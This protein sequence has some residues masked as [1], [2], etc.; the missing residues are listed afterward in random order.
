VLLCGDIQREA[1][2]TLV[3]SEAVVSADVLELPHHGSHHRT[4]E[5][6]V[7]QVGPQVTLQSTGRTRW[8]RTRARWDPAL[9][10]AEHLVTARDG[11]CWVRIDRQG[12]IRCGRY[13]VR[14]SRP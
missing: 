1:M 12:S 2:E 13:R 11:A 3:G 4:A 14:S 6:F 5:L 8:K 7:G 10:G 9:D